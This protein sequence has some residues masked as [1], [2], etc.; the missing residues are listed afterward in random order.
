LQ[1]GQNGV[2]PPAAL[3]KDNSGVSTYGKDVDMSTGSQLSFCS[4]ARFFC[5]VQEAEVVLHAPS[6][7]PNF[8]GSAVS[9]RP[10]MACARLIVRV[11]KCHHCC[12][13]P[14]QLQGIHKMLAIAGVCYPGMYRLLPSRCYQ[15]TCCETSLLYHVGGNTYLGSYIPCKVSQG[16]VLKDLGDWCLLIYFAVAHWFEHHSGRCG[17]R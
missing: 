16:K 7:T 2:F 13:V 12:A 5:H 8:P 9:C 11:C 1:D 10:D 6:N 15:P 3:H 4:V 17:F 14:L